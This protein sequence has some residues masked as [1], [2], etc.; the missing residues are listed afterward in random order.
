[1]REN[2]HSSMTISNP[3]RQTRVTFGGP[4]K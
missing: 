2:A 1:M 3:D 4:Q